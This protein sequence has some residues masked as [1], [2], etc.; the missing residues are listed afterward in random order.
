MKKNLFPLL[1]VSAVL[2]SCWGG[3]GTNDTIDITGVRTERLEADSLN[4]GDLLLAPRKIFTVGKRLAVLEDKDVEGFIHFFDAE[5][6]F[7]G[8]YGTIG[9]S[10]ED[11]I[12]PNVFAC[13]ESLLAVSMDGSFSVVSYGEDGPSAGKRLYPDDRK[14]FMGPNFMAIAK[15]SSLIIESS[16]SEDMIT[17]VTKDGTAYGYSHYPIELPDGI[18]EFFMKTVISSCSYAISFGGDTLFTAFNY[19]P[20]AGT[21]T[22]R[23]IRTGNVWLQT[24]RHNSFRIRDGIPY[25]E[26][27]ILFYT[28]SAS[29][30]KYFYA[31]FQNGR[32]NRLEQ[33]GRSEIHRFTR[34]GE[35][36]DRFIL[37][38]RI[39]HFSVSRDDSRLFALG[40]DGNLMP[41]IY[42]YNI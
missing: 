42:S 4:A 19:Y 13:E 11:Y 33:E 38:R 28:Y 14:L 1:A 15:D 2:A 31:L 23:G 32:K 27:P 26:N 8:K 5:G 9:R 25:Y 20:A 6:K 41:E 36:V 16:S 30:E 22:V 18:P 39:Y 3:R 21:A 12:L 40:T 17:V 10:G 37:D 7:L 24:D 29:S 35:L 34:N